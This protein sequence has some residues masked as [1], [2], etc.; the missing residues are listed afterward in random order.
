MSYRF[1]VIDDSSVV[2]K[3]LRK[4]LAMTDIEMSDLL[5]AENGQLGLSIVEKEWVD[6][7]F[8]DIN[9]PVMNGVEFL[10]ELRKSPDYSEMPV[11]IVS[12]EGS[13]ERIK[14]L[15]EL[16]IQGYLR[17]PVGPEALVA[18]VKEVLGR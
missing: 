1:L 9:M 18:K 17:K 11:V 2:R 10:R 15:E 7:V 13:S 3:A 5:E 14:E 4:T 12:T 6:L 16:G 8:L